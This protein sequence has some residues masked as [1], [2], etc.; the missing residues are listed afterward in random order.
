MVMTSAR[1]IM[2][3]EP[4]CLILQLKART[5]KRVNRVRVTLDAD[6]TYTVKFSREL[7]VKGVPTAT[8]VSEF[9][10]VYADQLRS[11]FTQETGLDTPL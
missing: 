3:W 9:A 11:L 2:E 8:L 7:N 1:P 5:K 4:D 6:D 10:G